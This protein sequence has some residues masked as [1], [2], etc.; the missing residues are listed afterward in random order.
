MSSTLSSQA[1]LSV[2]SPS[3]GSPHLPWLPLVKGTLAWSSASAKPSG[4]PL[5]Y[6]DLGSVIHI[7]VDR[8]KMTNPIKGNDVTDS[9]SI[10][11]VGDRYAV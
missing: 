5:P 11:P 4:R 9:G 8:I 10:T 3:A 6:K 7:R 1:S 2:L